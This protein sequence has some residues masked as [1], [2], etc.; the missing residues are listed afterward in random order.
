MTIFERAKAAVSPRMAAE[1]Y[2]LTVKRSGMLCCPF[3]NDRTPSMKLYDD[4]YHC[5]GCGAHG[6]V[7][8]LAAEILGVSPGEA[9]KRLVADFG[10][11]EDLSLSPPESKPP[12]KDSEEVLDCRC[13]LFIYFRLLRRWMEEFAPETPDDELDDRFIEACRMFA[14]I[15]DMSNELHL[16]SHEE[17]EQL[18]SFLRKNGTLDWIEARLKQIPEELVYELMEE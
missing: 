4:H 11:N 6:D 16:A 5:F 8:D 17:K 7:I 14:T 12:P 9:A 3:H 15:D 18:V 2:G 13:V 1:H 10:V